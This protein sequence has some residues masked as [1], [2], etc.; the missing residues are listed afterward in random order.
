M[1]QPI[2]L[3]CVL[4]M[5]YSSRA[6]VSDTRVAD[7]AH[8]ARANVDRVANVPADSQATHEMVQLRISEFHA[9]WQRYWRAGELNRQRFLTMDSLDLRLDRQHC[10]PDGSTDFGRPSKNAIPRDSVD[11]HEFA[12]ALIPSKHSYFA[13]CPSWLLSSTV[14]DAGDEALLMD[15][16]LIPRYRIVVRTARAS[17][18]SELDSVAREWPGNVWLT[19]QRTRL[20][21]DQNDFTHALAT[22]QSCQGTTWWCSAL[23]GWVYARSG[24]IVQ[25]ESAFAS[26]RRTMPATV[27]CAWSDIRNLLEAREHDVYRKLSCEQRTDVTARLWWLSDPLFR[28]AGNARRV[29]DDMRRVETELR[30][31]VAYDERYTWIEDLGADA[32]VE[33]MQRYGWPSYAANMTV[34]R[35][36]EVGHTGYL[37][38]ARSRTSRMTPY[39][40]FEYTPERVHTVPKWSMVQA[41]F[42]IADSSWM[43][44]GEQANG[45]LLP[46]WWP[47]EHFLPERRLRQLPEG[48]T[49]LFRRSSQILLAS[50]VQLS[51][52]DMLAASGSQYSVM[53]LSSTGPGQLDSLARVDGPADATAVFRSPI[54]PTPRVIAIEAMGMGAQTLD[55]RARF[56]VTPPSPLDSM[57]PGQV[58]ISDPVVL[59]SSVQETTPT[60]GEDLLKRM[61]GTTRLDRYNRRIGLYWETYG[62]RATDTVNVSVRIVGVQELGIAQ[63]LGRALNLSDDPNGAIVQEWT[64]PDGQRATRTVEGRVPI[65]MRTILLNLSLLRPGP[66][67]IDVGIQQKNGPIITGQRRITVL[68]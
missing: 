41:P 15:V 4:W 61:M 34:L 51:H 52:P 39:T 42:A 20:H 48:Q 9:L 62:I 54:A 46:G 30:K 50:A 43:L 40:T 47:T 28:V 13:T 18:L 22:A 23:V 10:H 35:S 2:L 17:L 38:G 27:A 14:E 49:G 45:S 16:A 19:G 36:S 37:N 67:R 66:Y 31:T 64:E 3:C 24:R 60:V 56:G 57:R 63:R 29:A 5:A 58:A 68:P 25:A 12:M 8:E 59:F 6:L 65:Q 11:A 26:M 53:L 44:R 21:V 33:T 32:L 55:A 1:I 7:T